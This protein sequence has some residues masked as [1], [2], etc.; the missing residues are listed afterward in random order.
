VGGGY[1]A[2]EFA[3]ILAGLGV[4]VTVCHRGPAVL[5]GFDME[6]AAAFAL[7]LQSYAS[8]IPS[9]EATRI[10]KSG[11]SLLVSLSNN[12]ELHVDAVLFATGR[13]PNADDIGLQDAGVE[14]NDKGAIVVDEHYTTSVS[15]IHAVGDVI[16]RLA[17]TPVALAEGQI[18]ARRLFSEEKSGAIQYDLIATAVFSQPC[19]STVGMDEATA[20]KELED[21]LVYRS[22]FTPLKHT[23][24]GR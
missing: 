12:A 19:I 21:V 11:D 1:I 2:V 24:T 14:F 10:R 17:L 3:G 9:T 22:R 20:R 23:M 7:E 6:I 15:N 16:D 8:V 18:V 4:E 13:K 5:R